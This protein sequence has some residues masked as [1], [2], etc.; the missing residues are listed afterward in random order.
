MFQSSVADFHALVTRASRPRYCGYSRPCEG[1]TPSPPERRYAG[2]KNA[3]AQNGFADV[4]FQLASEMRAD[5]E[6]P[7]FQA[8]ASGDGAEQSG[9]GGRGMG[10]E[11]EKKLAAKRH[12][13]MVKQAD[14]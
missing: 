3:L 4:I 13:F 7:I 8:L 2:L 5:V 12:R 9:G 10:I 6:E 1:E 11:I 14:A